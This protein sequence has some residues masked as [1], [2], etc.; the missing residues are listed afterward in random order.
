MVFH[1]R[2][3]ID[4]KNN[5]ISLTEMSPTCLPHTTLYT[6]IYTTIPHT[7]L[8]TVF[9]TNKAKIVAKI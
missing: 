6:I 9:H 2:T 5:N 8:H 7:V 1:L 3:K 4:R